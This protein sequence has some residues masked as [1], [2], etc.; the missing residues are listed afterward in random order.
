MMHTYRCAVVIPAKNA[1]SILPRVLSQVVS[2]KT[3]W[4]YE[5]IVIDSGSTDGTVEYLRKLDTIRLIEIPSG[6]FGHGKTRNLGVQ[7]ADA[8]FLEATLNALGL[9]VRAWQRILKASCR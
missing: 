4:P 6:E 9:S 2:Q 3:E 8:E 7:A 1:I 5:V